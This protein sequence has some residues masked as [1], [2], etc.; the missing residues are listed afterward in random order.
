MRSYARKGDTHSIPEGRSQCSRC[1][2]HKDNIEF[3]YYRIPEDAPPD[4]KRTK[5]NSLCSECKSEYN[6]ELRFLK[7]S[8]K[9]FITPPDWGEPCEAC[10]RPSY[11][12][13]SNIP[14]GV[15]GT[16]GFVPDHDHEISTD[17]DNMVP[18]NL[19]SFRGWS[20]KPCNTGGG[21]IGDTIAA[22]EK[23]LEYLKR[24]RDFQNRSQI[25][26][27]KKLDNINLMENFRQ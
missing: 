6:T 7:S 18:E 20:C 12:N 11:E 3:G 8:I 26:L 17:L 16:H 23:Y 4:K 15:N 22:V 24:A 2:K 14:D 10:E 25:E 21:S 19:F 1:K 5:V 27:K 9:P 13:Q